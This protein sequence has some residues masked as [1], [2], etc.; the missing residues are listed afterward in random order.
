M[1]VGG[2]REA[3]RAV[4]DI[5]TASRV[6]SVLR[7]EEG[8]GGRLRGPLQKLLCEHPGHKGYWIR[9]ARPSC[10]NGALHTENP[11]ENGVIFPKR[12]N[13]A[14]PQDAREAVLLN[15]HWPNHRRMGCSGDR[16]PGTVMHPALK[17]REG[18][19]LLTPGRTRKCMLSRC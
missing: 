17:N 7:W 3:P 16:A 2:M 10:V 18:I 12:A 8:W 13:A 1:D 5:R 6:G 19:I 4:R 14:E 11:K 15:S 9:G